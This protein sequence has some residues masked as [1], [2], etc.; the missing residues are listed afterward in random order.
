YVTGRLKDV[1]IVRGV[2]HY[3]QDLERTV[4]DQHQE[5]GAGAVAAFA[6]DRGTSG[7][8]I[9]IAAE[10][11]SRRIDLDVAGSALIADVRAAVAEIHGVPLHAVLLVACGAI[12]R[13]RSGKP[14]RSA[15]A[16]QAKARTLPVLVAWRESHV[17]GRG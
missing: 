17:G 3:P 2:K 8:F 15:C 1:L 14:Q 4:A 16:G 9:G 10:I 7:D 5:L 6:I 12:P 13:T 11:D